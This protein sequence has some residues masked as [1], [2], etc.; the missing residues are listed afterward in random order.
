MV[1]QV[2]VTDPKREFTYDHDL[3]VCGNK[4][5]KLTRY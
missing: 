4:T 5:P 2:S 3:E 1:S